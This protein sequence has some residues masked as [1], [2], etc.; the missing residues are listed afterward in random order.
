MDALTEHAWIDASL[1]VQRGAAPPL[2]SP[3]PAIR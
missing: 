2:L 3:E 1:G